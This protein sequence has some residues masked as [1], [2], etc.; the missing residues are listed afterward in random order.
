MDDIAADSFLTAI[1]L[2]ECAAFLVGGIG[3]V[4]V[5]RDAGGDSCFLAGAVL[6]AFDFA[7]A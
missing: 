5:G 1:R 2:S 7:G 3:I 6:A 4:I